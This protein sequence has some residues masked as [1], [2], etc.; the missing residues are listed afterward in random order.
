MGFRSALDTAKPNALVH[1]INAWYVRAIACAALTLA[2]AAAFAGDVKLAW[3]ASAAPEVTGYTVYY[4]S[5]TGTYQSNVDVG[6]TTTYTVTGLTDGALYFFAV[7]AHDAEGAESDFS[8]ETSAVVVGVPDTTAPVVSAV[9]VPVVTFSGATIVWTTNELSNSQI[10]FGAT[11]AYGTTTPLDA[12]L[13]ISHSVTLGGLSGNTLYHY[14]VRSR[15]AAGNLRVSGDFTFTTLAVNTLPANLIAAYAYNEGAGTVAA[16][17]SVHDNDA[18]LS[19]AT[20]STACKFGNCLSFNGPSHFVESPDID[21]LTPGTTAT[22]EAWIFPSAAPSDLAPVLNKWTQT[23]EDEYSF[24]LDSDRQVYFAWQTTAGATFGTSSWN[25]VVGTGTIP[26]NTWTHIAAVRSGTTLSFYVNGNLDSTQVV[27]DTNPF[28]NGTNPLR[29]GGETT[30]GTRFFSGRI[31]EPRIYGRAL[32]QAEIQYDMNTAIPPAAGD[33]TAPTISAVAVPV[34]TASGATITWTTNEAS[35]TQVQYGLT[36]SYGTSTTINASLVTAHSVNLTGLTDGTLYHFRVRSRDAAGNLANSADGTFTTVDTTAPSV[37]VSSP[38]P[39]AAV[40][41]AVTVTVNAADNV[42]VTQVQILVDGTPVVTDTSAPFAAAWDSSSVANGPHTLTAIA[43]DL[44]GNSRTS[45]VV[46]VIVANDD[47]VVVG[48]G[49]LPV[50]GGWLALGSKESNAFTTQLWSKVGWDAYF[51]SNGE[52]HTAA[53]DLDGDG[54]DEIVIGFGAGGN[55]WIAILDDPAHGY[56]WI[57][58]LQVAWPSYN[59]AN[60]AVYPAVGDIDGD[61]RAEIVAGLGAGS[62]GF[63]EIFDDASA[64]YAHVRWLQVNWAEYNAASGETHPAVAD[65]DGDGRA[66]IMLGLGTGSQGFV[67]VRSGA[68]NYEHRRWLQVLF[69]QYNQLNGATFPA[70]GDLDDDGRAE[71]VVGLGTGGGGWMQ[72][73]DD[74]VASHSHLRWLQI[75]WPEYNAASGES[76][77][78]IGNLDDDAAAEIVIGLGQFNGGPGGW[79]AILDDAN[80]GAGYEWRGWKSVGRDTVTQSGT[81]TFPAVA[82]QRR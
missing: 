48:L 46:G 1:H 43:R 42:G 35:D 9:S 32:S 53:G 45:A 58:W 38:A 78:A 66:E 13:L 60:G 67:E 63:V 25:R 71:I 31:D 55:G 22:F 75:V 54:L 81:A 56:A 64:G 39:G 11:T 28:R 62:G 29:V 80:T 57:R 69:A 26:L 33:T 20:W 36:A 65:L 41:G 17:G 73:F 70:A 2:P 14:R 44:A 12:S 59:A 79:F 4:G 72:V 52:L 50:N 34:T 23:P 15:D 19:G 21:P 49:R 3:D 51:A 7:K 76:H 16:D 6:N 74:A 24:G 40:W 30:G 77:P 5:A 27:F 37:S 18:T 61:G 8:N 47:E 68:P 10:D 82:Q